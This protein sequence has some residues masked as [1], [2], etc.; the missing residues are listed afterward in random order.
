MDDLITVYLVMT[1]GFILLLLM[2]WVDDPYR[3]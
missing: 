3:D 2:I 1:I